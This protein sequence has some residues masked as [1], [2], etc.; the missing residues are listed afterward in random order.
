MPSSRTAAWTVQAISSTTLRREIS[1][2]RDRIKNQARPIS[3]G[4]S[5]NAGHQVNP[6]TNHIGP[7]ANRARSSIQSCHRT[8]LPTSWVSSSIRSSTS[9][10]AC[11]P[12]VASGWRK[13]ALIPAGLMGLAC[14]HAV[15]A[16]S[17]D[18]NLWP[19]VVI[20]TAPVACFYL[21]GLLG[22]RF[23]QARSLPS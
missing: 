1:A 4:N 15:Y 21:A 22:L 19:I 14:L 9:P 8:R 20:L 23:L 18:S 16:L 17:Q 6:A 13:A 5:R 12:S 7:V 2:S 3:T 11:S 10:A